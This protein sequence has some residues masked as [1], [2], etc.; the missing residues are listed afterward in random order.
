MAHSPA[1]SFSL[2]QSPSLSLSLFF[3]FSLSLQ[4]TIWVRKLQEGGGALQIRERGFLRK[5]PYWHFDLGA[6]N[7]E[8]INLWHL[9][10]SV[11]VI[12][13][14]QPEQPNT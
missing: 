3:F 4:R 8:K 1:L 9:N 7:C 6:K 13:L 11:C 14:W 5:Q 12:L 2:S 10:Q